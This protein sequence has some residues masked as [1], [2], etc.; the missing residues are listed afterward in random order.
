MKGYSTNQ[1]MIFD[2]LF[3]IRHNMDIKKFLRVTYNHDKLHM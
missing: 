2:S 1:I 3:K